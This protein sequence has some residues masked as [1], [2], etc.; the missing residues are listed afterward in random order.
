M[1][2]Q[3]AA[4][5]AQ[6]E[7]VHSLQQQLQASSDASAVTQQ[8][9]WELQDKE[10]ALQQQLASL[11]EA[12]QAVSSER[13]ASPPFLETGFKCDF[14]SNISFGR[15]EDVGVLQ[16]DLI[17]QLRERVLELEGERS[18]VLDLHDQVS[19][20]LSQRLQRLAEVERTAAAM[21][22]ALA[23]QSVVMLTAQESDSHIQELQQQVED[24]MSID[25][26]EAETQTTPSKEASAVDAGHVLGQL[27]HMLGL[28]QQ[29]D[30]GE[31]LAAQISELQLSARGALLQQEAQ[32][33]EQRAAELSTRVA[34]AE[35]LREQLAGLRAEAEA[36]GGQL[37]AAR[38][39][40]EAL[41]SRVAEAQQSLAL[42]ERELA[43]SQ[44]ERDLAVGHVEGRLRDREVEVE[45]LTAQLARA[46]AEL[47]ELRRSSAS[48]ASDGSA[49]Q[50][51]LRAE[52][53]AA[54]QE[55]Q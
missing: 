4:K 40:A 23:G 32:E 13:A 50:T 24:Y 1:A 26:T 44:V 53:E 9:M 41:Q 22:A 37:V 36:A 18:Q 34:E 7:L 19:L 2:A 8:A 39:E 47:S 10:K 27:Q 48:A 49:E 16:G 45:G 25:K 52:A 30:G 15:R 33:A 35:A 42:R 29:L 28:I 46:E 55:A 51:A 21:R 54:R 3:Q 11:R 5:M 31:A 20:E 14:G 12:V 17:Q 43:S 38:A 6:Q